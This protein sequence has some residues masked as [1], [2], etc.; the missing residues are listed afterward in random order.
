[1]S[2]KTLTGDKSAEVE[3]A[4]NQVEG[5]ISSKVVW[6]EGEI[7]EIHVLSGKDRNAKQLVRDIET[8]L[9]VRAGINIDHKKIS[10]AQVSQEKQTVFRP[11]LANVSVEVSDLTAVAKV[12]IRY[13]N[14]TYMAAAEGAKSEKNILRL[15]AQ[16]TL[17]ALEQAARAEIK[18]AVDQVMVIPFEISQLISVAV[19]AVSPGSEE[20][21]LG[22]AYV[23]GNPREAACKAA[24]DAVNRRLLRLAE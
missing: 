21:L 8:I 23:Q 16:A 3:G 11:K 14:E 12:A 15:A 18:F 5:V 2:E 4:I 17:L 10:I 7:S 13:G 22:S 1:V 19:T 20:N 6:D 9:Q 24:L